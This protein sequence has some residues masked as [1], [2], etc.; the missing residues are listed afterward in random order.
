MTPQPVGSKTDRPIH[1]NMVKRNSG[2]FRK[3]DESGIDSNFTSYYIANKGGFKQP[4]HYNANKELR[5]KLTYQNNKLKNLEMKYEQLLSQRI[6]NI[7]NTDR[8]YSPR[9]HTNRTNRT[10]VD[11]IEAKNTIDLTRNRVRK[12]TETTIHRMMSNTDRIHP[13]SDSDLDRTYSFT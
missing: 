13:T 7:S 11:S 9:K 2:Y 8:T 4:T 1:S 10:R 6:L 5:K 12:N 3:V